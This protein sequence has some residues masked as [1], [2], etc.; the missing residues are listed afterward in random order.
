[1]N[2]NSKALC[3]YHSEEWWL[4]LSHRCCEP[5]GGKNSSAILHYWVKAMR[6][7]N[8]FGFHIKKQFL[9]IGVLKDK[10][11]Y[12]PKGIA[13]WQFSWIADLDDR[14]SVG[15]IQMLEV[16]N[17]PLK[18]WASQWKPVVA[19]NKQNKDTSIAGRQGRRGSHTMALSGIHR[20]G[21][22]H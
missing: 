6:K 3:H 7:L 9:K 13:Y 8:T 2:I 5:L 1:M 20:W 10:W 22:K 21:L 15:D 11:S 18:I 12:F 4:I 17:Q 14:F 19:G 16:V